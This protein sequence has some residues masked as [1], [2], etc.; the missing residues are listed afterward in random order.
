METMTTHLIG[1]TTAELARSLRVPR[2][3]DADPVRLK[4]LLHT[5]ADRLETLEALLQTSD[6]ALAVATAAASV[7]IV[8]GA[9][10]PPVR[11]SRRS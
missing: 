9:S 2:V 4:R 5:V 3:L 8:A 6:A 10:A 1:A 11:N 7:V